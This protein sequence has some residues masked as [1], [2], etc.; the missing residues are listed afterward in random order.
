MLPMIVRDAA[1]FVQSQR[2]SVGLITS[3]HLE[4]CMLLLQDR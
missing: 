1:G 2:G 4:Y 3:V